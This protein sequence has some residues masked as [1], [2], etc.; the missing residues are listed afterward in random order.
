M[1]EVPKK[2]TWDSQVW[3]IVVAI[4]IILG[5]VSSLLDI[6]GVIDFWNSLIVPIANFFTIPIPLY[7]IPLV[8]LVVLAILLV[9]MRT[10]GSNAITITTSN[11]LDRAD[12]LDSEYVRYV[13]LLCRTPQT[14]DFL[15]RK[16]QESFH[17]NFNRGVY[18][19]KDC[20]KE[21][22]EREL[23][24]FQDGKWT[25]TRKALDYIAKFHGN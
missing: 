17:P 10:G 25:V 22:E 4:G 16:Y 23:V 8:F 5:I 3:K 12:I 20:L 19:F 24:I 21:L 6:L 1:L 13:A 2:S 15:K 14:A 7:S 9:S 18:S 11:P